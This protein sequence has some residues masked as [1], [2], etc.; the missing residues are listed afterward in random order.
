M[1]GADCTHT[2]VVGEAIEINNYLP[3]KL[4]ML[5]L[6]VFSLSV[7]TSNNCIYSEYSIYTEYR[8]KRM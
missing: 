8:I 3:K 1:P 4:Y 5:L 2:S 6:N 7:M